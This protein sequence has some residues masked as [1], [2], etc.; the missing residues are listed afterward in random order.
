MTACSIVVLLGLYLSVAVEASAQQISRSIDMRNQLAPIAREQ[1]EAATGMVV[2]VLSDDPNEKEA[3]LP[4]RVKLLSVTPISLSNLASAK[5]DMGLVEISL[6]NIG[7]HNVAIPISREM[8]MLHA[9][10]N[11]DRR[12]FSCSFKL[13]LG[14]S[15]EEVL[16]RGLNGYSS[17]TDSTTVIPLR[18]RETVNIFFEVNFQNALTTNAEQWRDRSMGGPVPGRVECSQQIL[19]LPNNAVAGE[20]RYQGISSGILRS[21]EIGVS[22]QR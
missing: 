10:G 11:Q 1:A 9:E 15:K 12:T 2:M 22:I 7:D 4:L 18:P 14:P 20:R 13:S 5:A 19:K 21:N 3:S 6:E 16:F 17:S 8:K